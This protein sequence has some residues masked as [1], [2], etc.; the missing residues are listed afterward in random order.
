MRAN[1]SVSIGPA[2][3]KEGMALLVSPD[4]PDTLL[5]LEYVQ[6]QKEGRAFRWTEFDP[7]QCGYLC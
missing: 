3:C 2:E 6:K 7:I 1:D 4:V 5:K